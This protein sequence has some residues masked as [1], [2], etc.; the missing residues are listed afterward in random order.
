MYIYNPVGQ[1]EFDFLIRRW[2]GEKSTGA[3]SPVFI[4]DLVPDVEIDIALPF[5]RKLCD[6]EIRQLWLCGN[7]TPELWL[8][9][10]IQRR[11]HRCQPKGRRR[12]HTKK[13]IP[14]N[15]RIAVGD[16]EGW[17]CASCPATKY[18]HFHHIVWRSKGGLDTLENLVMLCRD[19]HSK[20]P[21]H[22]KSLAKCRFSACRPKTI[23]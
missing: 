5:K 10:H 15:V 4:P 1:T 7:P 12:E 13:R 18:L 3:G 8:P 16:R 23:A 14:Q 19:C 22:P 9:P 17:K 6:R 21:G 20:Q 11:M 2:R